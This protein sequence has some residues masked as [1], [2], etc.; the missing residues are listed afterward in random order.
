MQ[1]ECPL[2]PEADNG[3]GAASVFSDS[4]KK[5]IFAVEFPDRFIESIS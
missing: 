3:W 1:L 4:G 2:G 5:R